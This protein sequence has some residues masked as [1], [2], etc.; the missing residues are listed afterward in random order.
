[1]LAGAVRN[2]IIKP[3]IGEGEGESPITE[4]RDLGEA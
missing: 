3:L 4:E 2:N 1:M